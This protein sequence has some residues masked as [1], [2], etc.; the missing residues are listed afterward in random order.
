MYMSKIPNNFLLEQINSD[1]MLASFVPMAKSK[2]KV[3]VN[4]LQKLEDNVREVDQKLFDFMIETYDAQHQT[5]MLLGQK[6]E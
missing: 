5:I 6:F 3:V 1:K 4:Q 2:R